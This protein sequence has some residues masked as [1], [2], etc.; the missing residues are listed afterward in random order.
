[1]QKNRHAKNTTNQPT[2]ASIQT[3]APQSHPATFVHEKDALSAPPP[4]TKYLPPHS[5]VKSNPDKPPQH[6]ETV[7]GNSRGFYGWLA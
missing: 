7:S 4:P 2:T 1:M 3:N 5:R 6:S